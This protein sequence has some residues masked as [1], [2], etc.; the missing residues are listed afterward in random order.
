MRPS[1][2]VPTSGHKVLGKHADHVVQ[3]HRA[4]HHADAPAELPKRVAGLGVL[5]A[6]P[7]VFVMFA[8]VLDVQAILRPDQIPAPDPLALVDDVIVHLGSR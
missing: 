1:V 8:V 4:G 5:V 6:L 3:L 7:G 2:R